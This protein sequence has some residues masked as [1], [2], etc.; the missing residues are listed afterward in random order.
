VGRLRGW[1]EAILL[2]GLKSQKVSDGK[3]LQVCAGPSAAT[4]LLITNETKR[5]GETHEARLGALL[6]LMFQLVEQDVARS[7]VLHHRTV[8]RLLSVTESR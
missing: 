1:V 6:L 4:N 8:F 2:K 5:I 3:A 7:I